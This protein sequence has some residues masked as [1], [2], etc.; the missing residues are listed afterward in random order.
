[1]LSE[2]RIRCREV[3]GQ[4]LAQGSGC[5]ETSNLSLRDQG[6]AQIGV[7]NQVAIGGGHEWDAGFTEAEGAIGQG[8]AV[9]F[10]LADHF[11]RID[12]GL[13]GFD[14]GDRTAIEVEQIVAGAGVG[15]MFLDC[16]GGRPVA[17]QSALKGHDAPPV[18][19]ETRVNQE[20]AGLAFGRHAVL[21]YLS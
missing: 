18:R 10:R 17:G 12:L 5:M 11:L 14:V 3:L 21:R 20:L 8:P 7:V 19:L 9:A 16:I 6:R 1:M 4:A 15:R 13:L 2:P